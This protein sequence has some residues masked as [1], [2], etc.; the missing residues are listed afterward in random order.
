MR[1]SQGHLDVK[2]VLS[3]SGGQNCNID[4]QFEDGVIWLA[5]IRLTDA[6][7]PPKPTQA[8]IFQ[9][10]VFTLKYLESTLVPTPKLFHFADESSENPVGVPFMLIE[11]MEG[12]PLEWDTTTS[13]QKTKVLEQLADIFLALEEHPFRSTGSISSESGSS[14][15]CGF[16]QPQLFDFP[17]FPLGPF[18][19][20]E[21]SLRAMIAQ[22]KNLIATGEV[23]T[24]GVDNYLS[25]CWR[26][27]MVQEVVSLHNGAGFYLKHFDDKGDH[28]LVDKDFN[29]T[30]IIDWEFAS[31]EPKA[32]AFSSP[33]ML[34][35][36]GDFFAGSNR[37]SSEEMEF[38]GIFE[39]RQRKDMAQ[40]VRNG[41]KMQRYLFPIGGGLAQ[42][43]EEFE[44]MFHG[45]QAA[46]ADDNS[47]LIP[48]KTWKDM[49]L[50][51]YAGDEQLVSLLQKE[52]TEL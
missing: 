35:P 26:E 20:L 24:L 31:L 30:G 46:W 23:S 1:D 8:Y 16:A 33:C 12:S 37:L 41:R 11:K 18:K 52:L 7:I 28:I 48:Y 2:N 32:L 25:F 38:A 21:S 40:I 15:V 29:I 3:Q 22:Q 43:Y 45:L 50:K 5:R 13:V 47:Q 49:A 36:V 34:W 39:R 42:E 17:D 19:D 27:D 9:S 6:L 44:A 4:I 14:K 51:R 10:E